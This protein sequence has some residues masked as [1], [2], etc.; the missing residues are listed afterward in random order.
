MPLYF[1][2]LRTPGGAARDAFGLQLS[3]FEDAYLEAFQAVPGMAADLV[4]EQCDPMC[5]GFMIMDA[6]GQPLADLPFTD[7]LW[8]HRRPPIS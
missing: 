5:C 1:F 6:E 4:K 8:R 2:H 3:G 7:V